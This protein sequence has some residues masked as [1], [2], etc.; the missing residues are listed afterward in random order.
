MRFRHGRALDQYAIGIGEIFLGGG[1]ASASERGAQTGHR[2]AVSYPG[3]IGNAHHSQPAGEQ[4]FDEIIFLVIEGRAAK[5]R[6]A[7]HM[8]DRFAFL[9]IDKNVRAPTA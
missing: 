9:Q 5:M 1:R 4:F 2:A 3:L 7:F 6:D 8:V